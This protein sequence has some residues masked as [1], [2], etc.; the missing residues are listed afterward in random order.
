MWTMERHEP[1]QLWRLWWLGGLI[2]EKTKRIEKPGQKYDKYKFDW[3]DWRWFTISRDLWIYRHQDAS[4]W[5]RSDQI[6]HNQTKSQTLLGLYLFSENRIVWFGKTDGLVFV[7]LASCLIFFYLGP[8]IPFS[9]FACF[10]TPGI[11]K[12]SSLAPSL[13]L[14]W[15]Y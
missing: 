3:F 2:E 15:N 13:I 5:V 6:F 11:L 7:T 10:K 12:S 8:L 4:L 14:F 9:P 1:W